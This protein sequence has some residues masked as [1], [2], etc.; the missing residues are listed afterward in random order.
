[1]LR[2]I[3]GFLRTVS[4]ATFVA[5]AYSMTFAQQGPAPDLIVRVSGPPVA[6]AGQDISRM[7]RLQAGNRGTAPAPGTV[8]ALDPRD[9]Y[10]VD[11]I[12]SS[13]PDV[14]E[15]WA[16]YSPNWA[17]DVL[18]RGGRTS[19][20]TDLAPGAS[21]LYRVGA[22]IPADTPPGWYRLCAHIDPGNRVV[23]SNEDNNTSCTGIRVI[24][25]RR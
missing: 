21:R 4:V 3:N 25:P 1:M 11:L 16:V 20:T 7:I 15:G 24:R 12:L 23:E 6:A 8:G 14:P 5:A 18:L 17:E 19:R 9:G 13:D 2:S 10:M 22:T